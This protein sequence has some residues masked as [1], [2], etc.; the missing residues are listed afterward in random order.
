MDN[1]IL[2]I[3]LGG[4]IILIFIAFLI[5]KKISKPQRNII[6]YPD[7]KYKDCSYSTFGCCPNSSIPRYNEKGTNCPMGGCAGTRYGCCPNSNIASVDSN[8]SNCR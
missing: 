3:I 7:N 6:Y 8:H 2:F 5:Y 1:I 4:V